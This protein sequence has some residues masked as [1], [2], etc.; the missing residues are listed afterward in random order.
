MMAAFEVIIEA[1]R[2]EKVRIRREDR[3][4]SR[5]GTD[6]TELGGTRMRAFP[7]YLSATTVFVVACGGSSGTKPAGDSGTTVCANLACLCTGA[8]LIISC[9]VALH[10]LP[11]TTRVGTGAHVDTWIVG[12]G[13]ALYLPSGHWN[14][15]RDG[16]TCSRRVDLPWNHLGKVAVFHRPLS[17]Y[18]DA[19][20]ST[21]G[22]SA[23][24]RNRKRVSRAC[25]QWMNP[26]LV[27]PASG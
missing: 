12:P 11:W 8:D 6:L 15:R 24:S 23:V 25:M 22:F 10:L 18:R 21:H 27:P 2:G 16:R 7:A 26:S 20:R 19:E 13:A 3:S 14:P 9:A 5:R 4:T 17:T 1:G